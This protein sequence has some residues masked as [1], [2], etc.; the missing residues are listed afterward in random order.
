MAPLVRKPSRSVSESANWVAY[1]ESRMRNRTGHFCCS[2]ISWTFGL[3]NRRGCYSDGM[4]SVARNELSRLTS[5]EGCWEN[6]EFYHH[7]ITRL[8][9]LE[10]IRGKKF[11]AITCV[12][13]LFLSNNP[14]TTIKSWIGFLRYKDT[15]VVN[16]SDRMKAQSFTSQY[17]EI[18]KHG[19]VRFLIFCGLKERHRRNICYK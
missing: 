9:E 2:S 19:D 18:L 1:I 7:D 12:F 17:L 16:I 14:H 11:D 5:Q 10:P 8:K 15:L 6:V 4:F 3:C 13:A